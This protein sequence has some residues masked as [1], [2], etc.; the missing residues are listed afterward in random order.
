[1][2]SRC[3][4]VV[5]VTGFLFLRLNNI[6]VLCIHC[7]FKIHLSS[8][9]HLGWFHLLFIVTSAAMNVGMQISLQ[10]P[11]F[12]FCFI[13]WMNTQKWHCW[14]ILCFYFLIFLR[15]LRCFHM[16][17]F[18]FPLTVH[19]DSNLSAAMLTLVIPGG[20]VF[21]FFFLIV[22][23]LLGVRWYL[24]VVLIWISLMINDVEHFLYAHLSSVR[25]FSSYD[26]YHCIGK[27]PHCV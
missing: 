8:D 5:H 13:S 9:R 2:P 23:I 24:S 22:A 21:S 19:R 18:T 1:M 15:N 6:L 27:I 16:H 4:H 26:R 17:Y 20:F 7:I 14:I 12:T 3:I 11:V 10:D 25:I